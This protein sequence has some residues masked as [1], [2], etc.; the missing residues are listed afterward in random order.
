MPDLARHDLYPIRSSPNRIA[1]FDLQNRETLV[2]V[3]VSPLEPETGMNSDPTSLYYE[4]MDS[5]RNGHLSLKS[6]EIVWSIRCTD[7]PHYV[8]T[9]LMWDVIKSGNVRVLEFLLNSGLR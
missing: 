8:L 5:H 6:T 9:R 1:H 3:L 7:L 2:V 4:L